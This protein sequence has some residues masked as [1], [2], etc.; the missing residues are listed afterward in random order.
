MNF[1]NQQNNEYYSQSEEAVYIIK[2]EY[3]EIVGESPANVKSRFMN[4]HLSQLG[5]IQMGVNNNPSTGEGNVEE[6]L[7]NFVSSIIDYKIGN[8][9]TTV[10]TKTL[11]N[12][13]Y[14][15][16]QNLMERP[17]KSISINPLRSNHLRKY[18]LLK[19]LRPKFL[20]VLN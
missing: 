19:N 11:P 7:V 9:T 6:N 17:L 18:H 15:R 13:F 8:N 14:S 2:G 12:H 10:E 3:D 1:R 5:K 4:N 16:N 20:K